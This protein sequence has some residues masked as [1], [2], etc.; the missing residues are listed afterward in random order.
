MESLTITIK[1]NGNL[2][3]VG[4]NEVSGKENNHFFNTSNQW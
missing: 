4:W 3:K 2:L 1:V